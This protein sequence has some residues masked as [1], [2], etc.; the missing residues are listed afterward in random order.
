MDSVFA[1]LR[2]T[3]Y[4][5]F[6]SRLNIQHYPSTS[7]DDCSSPKVVVISDS[8]ALDAARSAIESLILELI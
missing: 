5:H 7:H 1:S 8:N 3:L 2:F 4:T 6:C